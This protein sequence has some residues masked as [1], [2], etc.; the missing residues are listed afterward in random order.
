[1]PDPLPRGPRAR[2][3]TCATSRPDSR[4]CD[5]SHAHTDRIRT[6]T[7]D[8]H[9]QLVTSQRYTALTVT[10]SRVG[11]GRGL[12]PRH[13]TLDPSYGRL[14]DAAALTWLTVRVGRA[15][16]RALQQAGLAEPLPWPN[17]RIGDA[18]CEFGPTAP[19]RGSDDDRSTSPT[20]PETVPSAGALV[21]TM[22]GAASTILAHQTRPVTSERPLCSEPPGTLRKRPKFRSE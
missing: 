13:D 19:R 5:R 6:S 4:V 15:L 11:L 7:D 21:Q 18:P 3:H 10:F 1:M 22:N 2:E 16:G 14:W 12:G 8:I 20:S 9:H 17:G